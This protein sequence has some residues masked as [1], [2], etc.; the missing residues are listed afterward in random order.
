[1]KNEQ[2]LSLSKGGDRHYMG[3]S[4]TKQKDA[5]RYSENFTNHIYQICQLNPGQVWAFY[6]FQMKQAIFQRTKRN[7]VKRPPH[8]CNR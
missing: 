6:A 2:K 7:Q 1:M 4:K 8:P 3:E 5:C